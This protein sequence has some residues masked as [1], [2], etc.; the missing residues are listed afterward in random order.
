MKKTAFIVEGQTEQVFLLKFLEQLVA[1][2]P[3]HIDLQKLH[4]GAVVKISWRGV[5]QCDATHYIRIINVENDEKVISFIEDNIENL[6]AKGFHAVYGLRDRYTGDSNRS[7]INPTSVDRRMEFLQEEYELPVEM[8]IAI[9]EVEAWF[10]LIPGFFQAY[11]A[12]LT[13][14][15]ISEILGFDLSEIDATK[16]DHPAGLIDKVLKGVGQRYKKRLDDS[17]RI[18]EL[19]DYEALYLE[20]STITPPLDRLVS[21]LSSALD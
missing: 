7:P 9:E 8:T 10:L 13:L 19:L 12:S 15:R 6:K 14:T 4:G 21:Q 3:C 1:L 11:D 5:P 18:A 16:L 20:K 2:Q 17:W